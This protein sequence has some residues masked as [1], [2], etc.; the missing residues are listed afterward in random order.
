MSGKWTPYKQESRKDWGATLE[1]NQKLDREQIQLGAVLR[2]ADA[3]E[4]IGKS[5]W[6]L[7]QRTVDKDIKLIKQERK[8][9]RLE[10]MNKQM[11]DAIDK[12]PLV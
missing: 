2:I 8:I 9:K 11:K 7:N 4:D 6:A 1:E 10:K 5:L 12:S 3:L